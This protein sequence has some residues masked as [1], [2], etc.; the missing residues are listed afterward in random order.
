MTKDMS[1]D[2]ALVKVL[3]SAATTLVVLP[4]LFL[5]LLLLGFSAM[6]T[7]DHDNSDCGGAVG[8]PIVLAMAGVLLAAA[9]IYAALRGRTRKSVLL[10]G[11]PA[12]VLGPI[13]GALLMAMMF[14]GS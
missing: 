7:D 5:C 8:M 10:R 3:V 12:L 6:C 4:W 14:F 9:Q 11:I 1:E 13:G 2:T